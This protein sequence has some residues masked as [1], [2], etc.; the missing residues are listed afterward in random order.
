MDAVI[1]AFKVM[2]PI[3][4]LM[5]T[6]FGARKAGLLSES[7]IRP[8]NNLVFRVFLPAMLFV[9]IVE[10][11]LTRLLNLPL[12]GYIAAV[13]SV[14]FLAAFLVVPRLERKRERIGVLIVGMIR[15]NVVYFGLPVV[16]LLV[17]GEYVGL[18]ALVIAVVAPLYNILSVVALE[19]FREGRVE[20][21]SVLTGIAR[22]PMILSVAAALLFLLVGIPIPQVVMTPLKQLAQVASPLALFLLGGSFSFSS[23]VGYGKEIIA[24]VLVKTVAVPALSL[25]VAVWIGF[26]P[27][28]TGTILATVGAPTAVASY[29]MAQQM[30]G[31]DRL[32]GQIVVYSSGAAVITIFCWIVLF[33][34]LGVI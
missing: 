9:S 29:A 31:D 25:P 33:K 34:Q 22:N 18:V 32:A 21:K 6:G 2:T 26:S 24:A 11:E 8:M 5:A 27:G 13:T 28:E 20:L 7:V 23:A 15:G 30:D 19:S 16:S 4:L 1:V 3:F 17:G 12:I 10:M 14:T